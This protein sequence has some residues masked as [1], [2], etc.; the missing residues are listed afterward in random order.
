MLALRTDAGVPVGAIGSE[1]LDG[2]LASL[3][4]V[5][6][7]RAVLTLQGRMLANEVAVRLRLPADR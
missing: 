2:P 1:D 5:R 4:D 7:D 3:L 6:G